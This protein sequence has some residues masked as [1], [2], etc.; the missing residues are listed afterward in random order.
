MAKQRLDKASGMTADLGRGRVRPA[1]CA[2]YPFLLSYYRCSQ[3]TADGNQEGL[4]RHR[5]A[6]LSRLAESALQ[7]TAKRLGVANDQW[8]A[9]AL[10]LSR[11]GQVAPHP[12]PARPR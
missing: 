7:A 9:V 5:P 1:R 8:K 11:P 4:R 6:V 10:E 2:G 12:E 3:G